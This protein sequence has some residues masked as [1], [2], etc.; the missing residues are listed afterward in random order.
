M[1]LYR[2][3]TRGLHACY[4]AATGARITVDPEVDSLLDLD[5][6]AAQVAA[7]DLVVTV[8]NTAAHMA[9]ALGAPTWLMLPRGNGLLWYW[10][11]CQG[12]HCPWYPSMRVFRQER[13]GDW[14]GMVRQVGQALAARRPA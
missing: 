8:S 13:A 3:E 11:L 9:G 4:R 5:L 7:M 14:S 10:L 1:P 6:Y 2:E 12:E